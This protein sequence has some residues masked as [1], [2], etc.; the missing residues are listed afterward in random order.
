MTRPATLIGAYLTNLALRNIE[1]RE[2]FRAELSRTGQID[3]D[4]VLQ[5]A[6]RLMIERCMGS[7]PGFMKIGKNAVLASRIFPKGDVVPSDVERIIRFALGEADALERLKLKNPELLRM[8]TFASLAWIHKIP[9]VEVVELVD[10]AE[11]EAFEA[12]FSPTRTII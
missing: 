10:R 11:R 5:A 2:R 12:G 3:V 4:G 9:E 7:S 6:L 8:L 1:E